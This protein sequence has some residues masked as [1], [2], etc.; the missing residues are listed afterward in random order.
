VKVA[1]F[2]THSN[3]EKAVQNALEAADWSKHIKGRVFIKPNIC[4]CE[5][6]SGAVTNPELLFYLVSFLRDKVD[7]V[8]VGESNGYNYN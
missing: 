3:L 2:R 6:I 1:V 8:I 5:F 7:E 4:S